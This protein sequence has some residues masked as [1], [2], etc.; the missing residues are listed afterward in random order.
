[1]ETMKGMQGLVLIVGGGGSGGEEGE[2]TASSPPPAEVGPCLEL[3]AD[4]APPL[5]S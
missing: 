4:F 3:P 2:T 5:L 1:M